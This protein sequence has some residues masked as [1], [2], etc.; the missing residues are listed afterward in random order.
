MPIK[1]PTTFEVDQMRD[2]ATLVQQNKIVLDD[3]KFGYD[4]LRQFCRLNGSSAHNVASIS[5]Q[6]T[7]LNPSDRSAPQV[8]IDLAAKEMLEK[9]IQR[10]VDTAQA[11]FD[12]AK[13]LINAPIL[14]SNGQ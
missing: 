12:K 13:E 1:A 14:S 8:Y 11:D 3:A 10:A 7:A 2:Q 5:V 6:L 4:A 9:I